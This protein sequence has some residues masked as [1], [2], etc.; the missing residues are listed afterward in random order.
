MLCGLGALICAVVAL[1]SRS[2]REPCLPPRLPSRLMCDRRPDR[3]FSL[4]RVGRFI[5]A[6]AG[7]LVL[8]PLLAWVG[9]VV[10][11]AAHAAAGV[12]L[13]ANVDAVRVWPRLVDHGIVWGSVRLDRDVEPLWLVDLAPAIGGPRSRRRRSPGCRTSRRVLAKTSYLFAMLLPLADVS[14][15]LAGCSRAIR[16]ATTT[17]RCTGTSRRRVRR[18]RVLRRVPRA[19]LARVSRVLRRRAVAHRVRRARDRDRR[20]VDAGARAHDRAGLS[21]R[22][23]GRSPRIPPPDS[24]RRSSACTRVAV[25]P[26]RRDRASVPIDPALVASTATVPDRGMMLR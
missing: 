25:R 20:A 13:G 1:S 2:R 21:Q 17:R 12:V 16:T 14:M 26:R 18:A 4:R 8:A 10:H 3:A 24:P 22:V 5:R 7:Y 6:N 9:T 11:E 23:T 15:S 19:R